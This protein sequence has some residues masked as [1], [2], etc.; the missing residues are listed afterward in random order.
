MNKIS[1]KVSPEYKNK[2]MT[3]G[4]SLYLKSHPEREKNPPSFDEMFIMAVE[5][6]CYGYIIDP[7]TITF[8]KKFIPELFKDGDN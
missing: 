8:F 6:Y 2:L 5:K 7:Q 1:V 3:D 4:L